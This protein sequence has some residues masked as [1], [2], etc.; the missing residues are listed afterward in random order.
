MQKI[1]IKIIHHTPII[2][3][4][5]YERVI[6]N[7]PRTINYLEAWYRCFNKNTEI[8]HPNIVKLIDCMHKEKIHNKFNIEQR[9]KRKFE[10]NKVQLEEERKLFILI[11]NFDF[12]YCEEYLCSILE[13]QHFSIN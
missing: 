3:W 8:C 10:I 9:K 11:E 1:F 4:N 13:N 5:V 2:F 7:I 6:N 12:L